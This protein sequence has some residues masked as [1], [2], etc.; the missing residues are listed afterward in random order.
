MRLIKGIISMVIL[1]STVVACDTVHEFPE[2]EIL[3]ESIETELVL[4]VIDKS[5]DIPDH[6]TVQYLK[7][8]KAVA[9]KFRYTV[10]ISHN[11]EKVASEIIFTNSIDDELRIKS[12]L[13]LNK[14]YTALV[15]VDQVDVDK[16]A[17]LY[18][19]TTS[20]SHIGLLDEGYIG[21]IDEKDA[22][23]G[24]SSFTLKISDANQDGVIEQKIDLYRP[25][26]KLRVISTDLKKYYEGHF[27]KPAKVVFTYISGIPSFYDLLN[28][29]ITHHINEFSV[30]YKEL[31]FTDEECT[32]FYDWVF[33]E[34]E[35][36]IIMVTF[37]IYD[38]DNKLITR[39][40]AIN[41]PLVRNKVTTVKDK[42]FTTNFYDGIGIDDK[43]EGEI[44]IEF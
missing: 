29:K 31:I 11:G 28:K 20:L 4:N 10:E 30:T 43:F 27:K 39:V 35:E 12:N 26:A 9:N 25:L 19:S 32:L 5:R 6:G 41:V 1:M 37:D 13:L 24:S 38:E 14:E 36:Q 17:D 8:A 18:Y 15:W 16:A 7:S 23:S 42:F 40:P 3:E 2:E 44:I 22:H 21:G 33:A 34:D